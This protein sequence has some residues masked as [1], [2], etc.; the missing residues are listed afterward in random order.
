MDAS[1][2]R[3][4]CNWSTGQLRSVPT[5]YQETEMARC[6]IADMQ[7][8]NHFDDQVFMIA[9]KDLRT[10]GQGSLYIHAVITDRSGQMLARIWQANESMYNALPEGGFVRLKGR[11]ESYKGSNQFIVDA[12]R[13]VDQATVDLTEF[14]RRTDADVDK[15]WTRVGEILGKI[16]H[17]HVAALVRAFLD[18]AELMERFKMA[19][20][21]V[22]LHHAYLGGLLEHT[23]TVLELAL[24]T[25][26]MYPKVSLDLVLAGVFLHD[27]GKTAELA[28]DISIR[29]SDPGQLLGHIVL[30]NT[31][32]E[33]KAEL[34]AT[35]L[36]EPFDERV[37]WSLQHIVVAHHGRYE[38]GSPKLPATPEA[39]AVHH[40]D[41]LDAK[42]AMCLSAIDSEPDDKSSWTSY[43]R[44]LE[45]KV[46][47]PDVL[48]IRPQ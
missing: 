9:S 1:L 12:I 24:V 37:K 5:R 41:N 18:D 20:A 47:M 34:A 38:F 19:P 2:T 11:V 46:F 26:P 15:L 8:G 44:A 25:I 40:L 23:C 6:F 35:A 39:I 13:P 16:K 48:G 31:W 42:L 27:I 36:G 30:A 22:Q 17:P 21:A 43:N 3:V 33:Q 14:L 7:P 32:I 4:A 28:Y 45:T 29:Y 10:T